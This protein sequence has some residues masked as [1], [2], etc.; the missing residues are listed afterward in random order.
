MNAYFSKRKQFLFIMMLVFSFFSGKAQSPDDIGIMRLDITSDRCNRGEGGAYLTVS[1][2]YQTQMI[3]TWFYEDFVTGENREEHDVLRISNLH[4]GRVGVIVRSIS[5]NNI[6]FESFK[7]V[8]NDSHE[9]NAT[10]NV[11]T[12]TQ[13]CEVVSAELVVVPTGGMGPYTFEW[14]IN[15][16]T[17]YEPGYYS[18]KV[19]D[20]YNNEC[21]AETYV[22]MEKLKCSI[23][24]NEII[25]PEGYGDE[26]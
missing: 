7:Y 17:V 25:G 1:T 10:I 14:G 13:S 2:I 9:F 4:Q 19:W 3:I 12:N 18:C 15:F 24:P 20:S 23:D 6:V 22:S 5:C 16:M 26:K 8:E 11:T 21:L